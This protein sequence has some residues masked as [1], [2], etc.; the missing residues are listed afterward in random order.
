MST[1]VHSTRREDARLLTGRGRYAADIHAEGELQAFFLRSDRAHARIV[2][3]DTSPALAQPGVA[4]VYTG[5]D[6]AGLRWPPTYAHAPGRGGK[7]VLQPERP[8]IVRER[9]RFVGEIVVMVVA[10]SQAQAQDAAEAIAVEYEELPVVVESRAAIAPGA[11]L[12]YEEI[13]ANT[14][15]EYEFGDE[16]RAD[17]VFASAP[18]VSRLAVRSQRL[19]SNPM[20]PRACLGQYSEATGYTLRVPTQGLPMMRSGL[21]AMMDE[22]PERLHIVAEDVGGGFGTRSNAEPEYGAVL[23][24]A[25]LLGRPVRWAGTRA[26]GFLSDSQGRANDLEGEIALDRE[27][28][29]LALRLHVLSNLGAYLTA[30][31]ALVH[32][33]MPAYCANGV[34]KIPVVHGLCTQALTNTAPVGAYRGA[35]RPD[36][37]YFVERM[38]D[39]AAI[40]HGFDRV[41]LRRKNLIPRNAFPYRNATGFVYDC[42]DFEAILDKGVA[43]SG[44]TGFAQRA[45]DARARGRLRGIGLAMAIEPSGGGQGKKEQASIR[46]HSDRTVTLH[47]LT[48]SNGQ[49]H[50]TTFPLL[51]GGL[52]G[53]PP[54]KIWLHASDADSTLSGFGTVGSR[55][56]MLVGSALKLAAQQV[57]ERARPL[58]AERLGVPEDALE[59]RAGAFT[60]PGGNAVYLLDL[61]AARLADGSGV[62][63]VTAEV[64]LSRSFPNGCHVAEVEIDPET[65]EVQLLTYTA[66]DDFGNVIN[67]AVV[68]GQVHGG[69]I[70]GA[71]QALG[72]HCVYDAETG[73][74]LTGSFADYY[75]PRA[76]G[77]P[78]FRIDEHPVPTATNAL[79]AKGAG[80]AGTTGAL[81][82]IMNAVIDALRPL[83]I[84]EMDMPA[85]PLRV[86]EALR[87][88]GGRRP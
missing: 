6:A 65:G 81:A 57:I 20:E 7:R 39:R 27:G 50:E 29:F 88:E 58:A 78:E 74:L 5:Q 26:E 22:A 60:A 1:P 61:G 82:A 67:H 9:V 84:V 71:G 13:P 24:A 23:L 59:F 19:V 55:S 34:Y 75:L 15:Y 44:W 79:G 31:G 8:I 16:S 68:E 69:V 32:S 73:Q 28:R 70:Q 66:V 87:R 49:G 4:A 21:S 56:L 85:T 52:L 33:T 64:P 54:E 36:I 83:G 17:A 14:C 35:G 12:L 77:I 53:I 86:W 18:L 30:T 76:D 2:S 25:R 72:E 40:D 37:A 45:A 43:L 10:E 42:G 51:V 63:D 41:E 38:V 11:P 47:S 3:L 80:E 48:Q 46:L 62:L